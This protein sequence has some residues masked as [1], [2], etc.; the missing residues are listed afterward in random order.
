MAGCI[1]LL[2]LLA[3]LLG[4]VAVSI[5]NR[6]D[7]RNAFQATAADINLAM[8]LMLSRDR[9]LTA[10]VRSFIAENPDA[11]NAAL[12][13]WSRSVGALTGRPEVAGLGR[14]VLVP[15]AE[16]PAYRQAVRVDPPA[17]AAAAVAPSVKPPG[18]RRFY[19]LTPISVAAGP[20][21]TL[22]PM[23]DLCAGQGADTA[24]STRDTATDDYTVARLGGEPVL[25]TLSPTYRTG[26]PPRTVPAR[27][28]AFT[29]WV[30]QA[31]RPQEM[32]DVARAGR[33][34]YG[35]RLHYRDAAGDV[36][37]GSGP[38]HSQALHARVQ[39]A[40]NLALDVFA[41]SAGGI[42]GQPVALAV[43]IGG[44]ALSLAL[45]AVVYL[46]GTG[47][48]RALRLV[49]ATTDELRRRALHDPATGLPNRTLIMDRLEQLMARARRSGVDEPAAL[50]VDL[51]GFKSINDTS[52][53]GV[54]DRLLAAAAARLTSSLRDVDTIGRM[55]GDEFVVLLEGMQHEA[56]PEAVA[57]RLLQ[58]LREPFEVSGAPAP[59][60]LTASVGVA[61]GLR[62][63]PEQLL[64]DADVAL[65][66]AKASG[67]NCFVVFHAAMGCDLRR[68]YELEVELRAALEEGQFRLVY[69]P[70]YA[71]GD[72]RMLGTEALLRWQHPSLGAVPPDEFIPLLEGSGRIHDVGRWVLH[73]A[74]RQ[75]AEWRAGGHDLTVAVNL[76]GRQLD[77]DTI[78]EDV[79][80]A[81]A[82]SGLEP[83]ALVLEITE[84]AVMMN[85]DATVHRLAALKDLGVRVS[86]D[87]FGTGY[88]SLAYL[89]RLP[90]DHLKI[91]RSFTQ[92]MTGSAEA[93]ALVRTL[94]TLG[95][96]L[97]LET[98]AEGAETS[99]QLEWLRLEGIDQVQGY[100]L[101]RPLEVAQLELQ[102]QRQVR[103][104]EPPVTGHLPRSRPAATVPTGG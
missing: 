37:F 77:R 64:R 7:A 54:G 93:Q 43:L 55:G 85:V 14:A 58:A 22:S 28:A 98:I 40:P 78:V 63:V 73:E 92:A 76:S 80:D 104:R 87:D 26:L 1:V 11:D 13:E 52:G 81:L 41:P 5:D 89:Q 20:A 38:D 51:D 49:A 8:R 46:L 96:S 15:A 25:I 86:I 84:T 45:A 30:G 61:T 91:D 23:Y 34:A 57:E 62:D 66:Q 75:A 50:Y 16:L 82:A 71:L 12:A 101:S 19:C 79:W 53:H 33:P 39:L 69:Q 2:G 95:R 36:T 94:A 90:V 103:R 97:G 32:L 17:G 60:M 83:V 4:A 74:C 24:L 56:G 29:G 100:L 3:S 65:H 99:E 31:L 47:R 10:G 59:I 18:A 72:L 6:N 102:L 67:R 21:W 35:V 48:S 9:D 44:S 88:S 68:R 42:A 70:I 27:R